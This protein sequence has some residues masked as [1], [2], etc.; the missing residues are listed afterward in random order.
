MRCLFSYISIDFEK[1]EQ[2]Q[3]FFTKK[4]SVNI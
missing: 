2:T 3:H 4:K 1:R